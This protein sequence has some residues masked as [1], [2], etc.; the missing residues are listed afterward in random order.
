M[1]QPIRKKN[2][3]DWDEM[4]KLWKG[5]SMD[6]LHQI[7][8]NFTKQFQPIRNKNINPFGQAISEEKIF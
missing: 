8:I 7:L 1:N 4:G 2:L 6:T 5:L 3:S